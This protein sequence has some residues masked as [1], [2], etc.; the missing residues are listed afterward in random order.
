MN[1]LQTLLFMC[2]G[3]TRDDSFHATARPIGT[4]GREKTRMISA[5][6]WRRRWAAQK[7]FSFRHVGRRRAMGVCPLPRG[8]QS[9]LHTQR[10]PF[11]IFGGTCVTLRKR[12]GHTSVASREA[13]ASRRPPLSRESALPSLVHGFARRGGAIRSQ[14]RRIRPLVA[15]TGSW[16]RRLSAERSAQNRQQWRQQPSKGQLKPPAHAAVERPD[17]P[18]AHLQPTLRAATRDR[19]AGTHGRDGSA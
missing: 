2:G 15:W 14:C 7:G 1:V 6:V 13:Q 4:E 16:Q 12:K 19:A 10:P 8:R 5:P 11:H 17:R 18:W 3:E 9:S